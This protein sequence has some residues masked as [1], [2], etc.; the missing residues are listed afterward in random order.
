MKII[1]KWKLVV[2]MVIINLLIVI[3]EKDDDDG[4]YNDEK[5]DVSYGMAKSLR[6]MKR[7]STL[8]LACTLSGG[9][10]RLRM[11]PAWK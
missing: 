4:F 2:E 10:L 5:L 1:K 11:D 7:I 8:S 3:I 9:S 6:W